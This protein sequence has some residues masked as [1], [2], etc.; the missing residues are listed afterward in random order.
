MFTGIVKSVATVSNIYYITYCKTV[1][2]M[3][4]KMHHLSLGKLGNFVSFLPQKGAGK[5]WCNVCMNLVL[6]LTLCQTL[7]LQQG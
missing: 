4:L 1:T 3:S 2:G 6:L 5:Q 7:L